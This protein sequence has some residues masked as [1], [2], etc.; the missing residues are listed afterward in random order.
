MKRR[1]KCFSKFRFLKMSSA[2]LQAGS[3]ERDQLHK[4]LGEL[5]NKRLRFPAIIGGK[6]IFNRGY[7]LLHQ[8]PR[9][10]PITWPNTTR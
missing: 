6:E 7:R 10:T 3:Q 4:A 9:N 5:Y 2:K 1:K 8:P